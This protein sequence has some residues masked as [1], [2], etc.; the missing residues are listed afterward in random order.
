MNDTP[1]DTLPRRRRIAPRSAAKP[2]TAPSKPVV[3]EPVVKE[4][5]ANE[6]SINEAAINQAAINEAAVQAIIDQ[7]MHTDAMPQGDAAQASE[8][9][10]VTTAAKRRAPRKRARKFPLAPVAAVVEP[11]TPAPE[12]E[13]PAQAVVETVAAAEAESEEAIETGPAETPP[14]C[15]HDEGAFIDLPPMPPAPP[16][17]GHPPQSDAAPEPTHHHWVYLALAVFLLAL[18]FGGWGVWTAWFA[19]DAPTQ[20]S[21]TALRTSSD[22]LSQDVSTLRR[23]DQI[24]R[25]ANRDLERALAERDEEIAGLR[26]DIAFYERFVGATGQ[27]RGLSVHDL[28]MKLQSGDAWHFVATLTQNL[29]RGAVNTGQVTLAVEGTRNDRL[30][31]LTWS[32]LR[33]Q[34]SAPGV[35]YSFK[36]FQQVEGEVMLPKDFKPLRVTVR[37]V[38]AGGSALDQSFP[39]PDAIRSGG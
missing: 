19:G 33:K 22:K 12:P 32:G 6:S 10:P 7:A 8:S 24:S 21:A 23:S 38:P 31:K 1:D 36:Y 34:T 39:W 37:L 26:A 16:D 28:E 14:S 29:N 11:L 3:K 2:R 30:E 5:S 25:E 18:G 4:P 9:S 27:R 35:S 20:Q 15:D 17:A 13:W